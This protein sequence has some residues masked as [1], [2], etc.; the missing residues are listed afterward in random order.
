MGTF[1]DPSSD[2]L[3]DTDTHAHA[4]TDDLAQLVADSA[5]LSAILADLCAP[6]YGVH[7][8]ASMDYGWE[9]AAMSQWDDSDRMYASIPEQI[10]MRA[11][12]GIGRYNDEHARDASLDAVEH[13]DK[14]ALRD[15]GPARIM[16]I[17]PDAY[18]V[19]DLGAEAHQCAN[20]NCE[21]CW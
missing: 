16:A 4:R 7:A 8:D 6:E 5:R 3:Q 21:G 20:G 18:R 19:R 12:G 15:Y 11:D 9:P 1:Y 10:M 17:M 2:T 14:Y 13:M